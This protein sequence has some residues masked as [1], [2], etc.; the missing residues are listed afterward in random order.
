MLNV[1][2]LIYGVKVPYFAVWIVKGL[3]GNHSLTTVVAGKKKKRKEKKMY[4]IRASNLSFPFFDQGEGKNVLNGRS[5]VRT[6]LPSRKPLG[7][8]SR[9]SVGC[10][11]VASCELLQKTFKSCKRLCAML[12]IERA[13]RVEKMRWV[14][15]PILQT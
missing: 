8:T 15:T 3:D 6:K 11:T 7:K 4:E 1:E 12:L 14:P 5:F 13:D 9:V 10:P 2:G